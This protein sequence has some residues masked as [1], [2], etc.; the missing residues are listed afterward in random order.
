MATTAGH[1][2]GA[3]GMPPDPGVIPLRAV[4]PQGLWTLRLWMSDLEKKRMAQTAI[5]LDYNAT[6]PPD[7]GV[8][9][10]MLPHL[11]AHFGNPSSGHAYGQTA[12]AAVARAREQVAGL[13]GCAPHELV[14]TS[15]GS[16]SNN[17][18]LIGTALARRERGDHIITTDVEH[19]SVLATCRY[20]G[21]RLGFSI[22]R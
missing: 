2:A 14:F 10:A 5:Y 6:T 20:L 7:P 13:L 16:E 8:V 9:E 22:S 21:G 1:A 12:G 11:Q 19:P 18:A 17:Q 15:G 3:R 4:V